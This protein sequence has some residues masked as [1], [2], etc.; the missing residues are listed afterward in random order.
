MSAKGSKGQAKGGA[1]AGSSDEEPATQAGPTDQPT[2]DALLQR[3]VEQD[4]RLDATNERLKEQ[5][6]TTNQQLKELQVNT[7]ER[8]DE[9]RA[10]IN[11]LLQQH[12]GVGPRQVSEAAPTTAAPNGDQHRHGT[13]PPA[14][15]TATTAAPASS[16]SAT[17]GVPTPTEEPCSAI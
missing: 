16:T 11:M 4:Q 10:G 13:A 3:I 6:A 7:N 2:L 14:T 12:L 17:Q 1:L 15:G 5:L 8:L 9:L